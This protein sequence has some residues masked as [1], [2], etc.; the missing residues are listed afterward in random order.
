MR[1]TKRLEV[2]GKAREGKGWIIKK[3]FYK[4]YRFYRLL[5]AFFKFFDIKLPSK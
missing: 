4:P 5:C 2:E 3:Y 1:W